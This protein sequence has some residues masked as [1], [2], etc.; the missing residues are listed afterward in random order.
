[1]T[2]GDVLTTD[3]V[4]SLLKVSVRQ[5]QDMAAGAELPAYR[6]G[7]KRRGNWRFRR[8]EIEAWLAEQRN[9]PQASEST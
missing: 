1:V 3:E 5:V 6:I 4:A 8:S 9:R 7:G 2:E